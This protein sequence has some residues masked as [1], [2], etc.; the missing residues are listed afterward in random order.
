[1]RL[2]IDYIQT[3]TNSVKSIDIRIDLEIFEFHRMTMQDLGQVER[4]S[5]PSFSSQVLYNAPWN[6]NRIR[7][8]PTISIQIS[9]AGDGSVQYNP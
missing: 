1:V 7:I 2:G 4:I 9:P 8:Y 5:F 3:K 6:P